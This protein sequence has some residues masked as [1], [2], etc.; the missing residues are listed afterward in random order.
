MLG[1]RVAIVGKSQPRIFE[2]SDDGAGRDVCIREMK[3]YV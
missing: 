3:L 2:E 1:E